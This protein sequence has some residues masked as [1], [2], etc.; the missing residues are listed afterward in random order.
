MIHDDK[1][2]VHDGRFRIRVEPLQ[3]TVY[4]Y[5]AIDDWL[6]RI[7]AH[8]ELYFA[9]PADCNDPFDCR[10][11]VTLDDPVEGLVKFLDEQRMYAD[12]LQK[13]GMGY[14][15][16]LPEHL[17]P[18]PTLAAMTDA[19]LTARAEEILRRPELGD[20]ELQG[21]KKAHLESARDRIGICCFA[22]RGDNLLMFAHYAAQH[23]GCCLE[24]QIRD[25][26]GSRTSIFEDDR[27]LFTDVVYSDEPPTAQLFEMGTV[28]SVRRVTLTKHTRWAYEEEVR[29]IRYGG[30]GAVRYRRDALTGVIF[31]Y[32]TSEAEVARVLGWLGA[33]RGVTLSRA[34]LEKHGD[35]GLAPL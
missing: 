22:G 21:I 33:R 9:T 29:V 6:E 27:L 25:G 10:F 26:A 32:R 30:P 18:T 5:R 16:P 17:A 8:D 23:R 31:G 12:M 14:D 2:L 24:F 19:E 35:L 20:A 3:E 15:G 28:D 34:T 7:L 13:A 11:E 1:G 4:R